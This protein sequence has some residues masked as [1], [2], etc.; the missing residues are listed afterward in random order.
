MALDSTPIQTLRHYADVLAQAQATQPVE[1]PAVLKVLM[2][3]DR[4]QHL[5]TSAP[6]LP[7]DSLLWLL[8]LDKD[9]G[10]LLKTP[11][12]HQGLGSMAQEPATP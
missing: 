5:L 11:S 1:P 7:D 3:R 12:L 2:A 9:L 6:A 10:F 4:V 8:A